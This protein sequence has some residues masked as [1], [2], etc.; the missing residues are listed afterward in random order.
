VSWCYAYSKITLSPRAPAPP[1]SSETSSHQ[2]VL[3]LA[4][5]Y[6][7]QKLE[8]ESQKAAVEG[9][10]L[11]LQS[12]LE[13]LNSRLEDRSEGG[14]PSA[15]CGGTHDDDGGQGRKPGGESLGVE[16][17]EARGGGEPRLDGEL[18]AKLQVLPD[19]L[20][21]GLPFSVHVGPRNVYRSGEREDCATGYAM[22]Y[23]KSSNILDSPA[24]FGW[25]SILNLGELR[26]REIYF[27]SHISWWEHSSHFRLIGRGVPSV[28]VVSQLVYKFL[29]LFGLP[30]GKSPDGGI[31]LPGGVVHLG[32]QAA[33]D[34][35]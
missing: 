17:P 23:A 14:T 28:S 21:Q 34:D 9:M 13:A 24:G 25:L 7:L 5:T 15:L 20:L 1:P 2:A 11:Q 27:K 30:Q 31:C 18:V 6:F 22:E 29:S 3:E 33:P 12:Q 35:G 26:E 19:L 16:S 10:V 32:W 4:C 8:A